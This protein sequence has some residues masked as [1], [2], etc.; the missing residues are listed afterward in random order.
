MACR[1]STSCRITPD[2][3][4]SVR[5]RFRALAQPSR[6]FFRVTLDDWEKRGAARDLDGR[7]EITDKTFFSYL[8]GYVSGYSPSEGAR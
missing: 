6:P 2:A 4:E 8:Q 3:K 1:R 7:S 5:K